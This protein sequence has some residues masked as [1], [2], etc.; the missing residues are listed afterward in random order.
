MHQSLDWA[1][2][3]VADRIVALGRIADE[4]ARVRHELKRDRVARVFQPD[5]GG[6]R[7]RNADRIALGNRTELWKQFRASQPR[8]DEILS[9]GQAAA[10][11]S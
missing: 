11:A 1:P 6:K 9:A 4:L 7:R 8:L 10:L 5:E 2:G 3:V